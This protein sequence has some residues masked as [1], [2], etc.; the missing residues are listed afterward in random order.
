MNKLSCVLYIVSDV[1]MNNLLILKVT[2]SIKKK[3]IF[4]NLFKLTAEMLYKYIQILGVRK[5]VDKV[6]SF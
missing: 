1:Y 4:L 5:T 2:K 3:R 6:V